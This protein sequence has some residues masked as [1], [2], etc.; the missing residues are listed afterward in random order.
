MLCLLL[1]CAT[2]GEEGAVGACANV[3][4][5]A[6]SGARWGCTWGGCVGTTTAVVSAG[7]V[8]FGSGCNSV[9]SAPNSECTVVLPLGE[10]AAGLYVPAVLKFWRVFL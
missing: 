9:M 3:L 5:P 4:A 7:A 2:G 1:T 10:R 6:P 8:A